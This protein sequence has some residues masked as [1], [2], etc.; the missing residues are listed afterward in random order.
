[1]QEQVLNENKGAL[2][3]NMP[4]IYIVYIIMFVGI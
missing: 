3:K 1:M 4:C 2:N